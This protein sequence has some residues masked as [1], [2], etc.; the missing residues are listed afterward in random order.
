M[1][2]R[3]RNAAPQDARAHQV[4]KFVQIRK[5]FP[6]L[7]FRARFAVSVETNTREDQVKHSVQSHLVG[8]DLHR[9]SLASQSEK[10]ESAIFGSFAVGSLLPEASRKVVRIC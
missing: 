4:R 2:F 10:L 7:V 9:S 6:D 5:N 8:D 1:K 3:V